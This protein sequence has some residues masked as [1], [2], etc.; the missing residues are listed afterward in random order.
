M[1]PP[2]Y[3]IPRLASRR[4]CQ[5]RSSTRCITHKRCL[6]GLISIKVFRGHRSGK[7]QPQTSYPH[8][9]SVSLCILK[10]SVSRR[11][12]TTYTLSISAIISLLDAS[13][14][15][16]DSARNDMK[17]PANFESVRCRL[18]IILHILQIY[19]K[20]L[21]PVKTLCPQMSFRL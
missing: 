16:Y 12:S 13:I 6:L 11:G 10:S 7:D 19:G 2:D 8:F 21:E 4:V 20:D 18:P 14:K 9:I 17:L 1:W 15:V 5:R 3:H